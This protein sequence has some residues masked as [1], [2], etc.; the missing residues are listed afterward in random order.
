MSVTITRNPN[1]SKSGTQKSFE[2][3][4]KKEFGEN[5]WTG[6]A[7]KDCPGFDQERNCLVALPLLNLKTLSREDILAYFNNSWTLT[8]LL[9]SSLKVEEAYIRPPPLF[10][11]KQKL[12]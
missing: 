2:H 12:S 10:Q 5:W 4:I 8:E 1:L 7:P 11:C 3:L 6:L 9:F